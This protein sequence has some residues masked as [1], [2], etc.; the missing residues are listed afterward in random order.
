[1]GSFPR[2]WSERPRSPVEREPIAV[3]QDLLD[4]RILHKIE[5]LAANEAHQGD[6]LAGTGAQ[7]P[8]TEPR[9]RTAKASPPAIATSRISRPMTR[10]M[11]CAPP[12]GSAR[13]GRARP[14]A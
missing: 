14:R 6:L 5:F 3:G 9:P 13:A 11:R 4:L 7:Y 12:S 8:S 1:M 10:F 2:N